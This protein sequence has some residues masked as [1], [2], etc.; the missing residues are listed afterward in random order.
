MP[1]TNFSIAVLM[2]DVEDKEIRLGS[3]NVDQPSQNA[4]DNE[5][6]HHIK[7]NTHVNK[8]TPSSNKNSDEKRDANIELRET[9]TFQRKRTSFSRLQQRMLEAKFQRAP[10]LTIQERNNLANFLELNSRQ[11]KVWFQNRRNK[12]KRENRG[13]LLIQP[14]LEMKSY[15]TAVALEN[16]FSCVMYNPY[17]HL[18]L[19]S[20]K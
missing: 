20:G 2:G 16:C 4:N 15:G 11:V 18:Y 9:T 10:Y 17:A 3:E 14:S 13:Q 1:V 6:L 19:K 7:G 12:W 5:L 8:T